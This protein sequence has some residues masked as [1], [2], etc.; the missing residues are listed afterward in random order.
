MNI[1]GKE[2][3]YGLATG[4]IL[5]LFE[6]RKDD[7]MLC[8][9]RHGRRFGLPLSSGAYFRKVF[10]KI[11]F[12]LALDSLRRLL[13]HRHCFCGW[14]CFPPDSHAVSTFVVEMAEKTFS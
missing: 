14:V 13:T 6:K 5:T 4:E 1:K 7:F 9:D 2:D 3:D 12:A 8:Q 11:F 10:S